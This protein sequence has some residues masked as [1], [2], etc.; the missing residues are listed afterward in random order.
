MGEEFYTKNLNLIKNNEKLSI[1][2][3]YDKIKDYTPV[4]HFI[5]LDEEETLAIVDCYRA[6]ENKTVELSK[7]QA[8]LIRGI[9]KKVEDLISEKFKNRPF[10]AKVYQRSTKTGRH[11]HKINLIEDRDKEYENLRI[12]WA[13]SKWRA[14]CTERE[15]ELNLKF[16]AEQ[17]RLFQN[18]KCTSTKEFMNLMLTSDN[19]YMDLEVLLEYGRRNKEQ[20]KQ[21]DLFENYIYIREWVDMTAINEYRCL[22]YKNNFIS[23]STYD[24][25]FLDHLESEQQ[26]QEVKK[27]VMTFWKEKIKE[28]LSSFETYNVD[29]AICDD[30]T[31]LVVEINDLYYCDPFCMVEEKEKILKGE[32]DLTD[33]S[34]DKIVFDP[35]DEEPDEHDEEEFK[36]REEKMIQK[37]QEINETYEDL[38]QRVESKK[39]C[40]IY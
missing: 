2:K 37:D 25:V 24:R 22:I 16:I 18:L 29:I 8:N 38:L 35:V 40:I 28:P 36:D 7:H 6:L 12:K 3:F 26:I 20:G 31:P 17:I 33:W 1:N 32:I 5:K 14:R 27:K 30:G 9:E 34:D 13:D 15:W 10:F 39:N 4:T 19:I 23:M 11:F 21:N